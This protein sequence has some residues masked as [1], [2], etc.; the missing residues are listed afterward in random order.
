[1]LCVQSVFSTC[2]SE[3]CKII[4]LNENGTTSSNLK[5]ERGTYQFNSI[6]ITVYKNYFQTSEGD[7]EHIYIFFF[8]KVR[9]GAK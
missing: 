2:P 7:R 6:M 1:M 8:S 3:I 5:L 9:G 4:F